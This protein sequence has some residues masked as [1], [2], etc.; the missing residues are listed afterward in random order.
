FWRIRLSRVAGERRSEAGGARM[1]MG[2]FATALVPRAA[3][4]D[5]PLWALL[6]CANL[7]DFGW[8]AL[9]VAGVEPT[10]P[11]SFLDVSIAGLHADMRFS[12][13]LVVV[14]PVALV[15]AAAVFAWRRNRAAALWCGAL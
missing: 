12:H 8:M 2:H 5:V 3:G 7:L 9:A 1:I 10:T 6:L 11:T 14:V 13:T 4:A 15:V